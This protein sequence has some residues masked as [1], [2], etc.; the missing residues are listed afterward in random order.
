MKKQGKIIEIEL[1]PINI[2]LRAKLLTDLN[3]D[4][5]NLLL[6]Y[7]PYKSVQC[8]SF[9]A[10]YQLYHYTPIVESVSVIPQT[11]ERL[12]DQPIGRVSLSALQL[13]P[14]KYDEVTEPLT[15][16]PIAQIIQTDI[17][18][19][20]KAGKMVWDRLYRTKEL[21]YVTVRIP[22]TSSKMY[23]VKTPQTSNK[24]LNIFLDKVYK[25]INNAFVKP[26][27]E[28]VDIFTGKEQKG[29]GT[30]N[31]YFATMVFVNGELR[32]LGYNALGGLLKVA[33]DK[34]VRLDSFKRTVEPFSK[35][36]AGF[37]GYVGLKTLHEFVE[38]AITLSRE[39]KYREEMIELFNAVT[40]Y[41]NQLHGWSLCYF[42]WK[43]GEYHSLNGKSNIS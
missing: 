18:N 24:K 23:K 10:G 42:P 22:G 11:E 43:Y 36:A 32:Q 26:P 38:E 5:C 12:I 28:L 30:Y 25:E 21:V 15:A 2:V 41:A 8:H 33:S 20:K 13:M 3:G 1:Q 40:T 31:Q 4:L 37:L 7:L 9:V 14:I 6:K 29:V 19:L 35:V 16:N 17:P 39:M 27:K 34:K